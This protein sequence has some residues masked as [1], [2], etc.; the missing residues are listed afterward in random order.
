MEIR[1]PAVTGG[2]HFVVV[3]LLF[4]GDPCQLP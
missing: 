1:I 3:L 2:V 4:I